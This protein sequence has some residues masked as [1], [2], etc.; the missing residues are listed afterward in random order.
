MKFGFWPQSAQS[1]D[2]VQSLAQHVEQKQW[3]GL[4]LAD[5]F[6]PNAANTNT[7]MAEVWTTIAALAATTKRLRLGTL[8]SGNT[9]RHPAILAKMAATVDHISGGRLVLGLGAAWQKNEHDKYGIPFYTVNNRLRRLEEACQI[10]KAL[11]NEQSTNFTGEFYQLTDAPLEPKP[12]QKNLPLLIGGGGEKLTL[13]IAAKYADEWNVWGKPDLL[14]HKMNILDQHCT[15]INRDPAQIQRSA[16]S[17]V[18]VSDDDAALN[19]M[20]K[21]SNRPLMAGNTREVQ[22]LIGAY[23]KIGVNELIIPDFNMGLGNTSRK[24]DQLDL[25]IEDIA[26]RFLE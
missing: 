7:P 4:W 18:F 19:K 17:L 25:F 16:V 13:K 10:I 12:K 20:S 11:Y 22:D 24:R 2:T 14:Q 23:Q 15:N 8:V 21:L 9:Y 26:S 3:H 1:F 5:H 6:M